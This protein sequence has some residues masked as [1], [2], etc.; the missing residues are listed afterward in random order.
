MP[1]S[2]SRYFPTKRETE[3]YRGRRLLAIRNR[4]S[5]A[6]PQLREPAAARAR[7]EQHEAPRRDR[8]GARPI[9]DARDPTMA[10]EHLAP[11]VKPRTAPKRV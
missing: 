7:A 10:D 6:D 5:L 11:D 4:D 2:S 9:A 3:R 1:A 8:T